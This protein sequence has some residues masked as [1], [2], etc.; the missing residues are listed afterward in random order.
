MSNIQVAAS[1]PANVTE[2]VFKYRFQKDD[3]G[4]QRP[5][6]EIKHQV[7]NLNGIKEILELPTSAPTGT[8][9]QNKE[10]QDAAEKIF[11]ANKAQQDLLLEAMDGIYRSVIKAWVVAD[12]NNTADKFDPAQF[13]WYAIATMEKEDRRSSAIPKEQWDSFGKDYAQIL[14]TVAGRTPEQIASAL[15]VFTKKFAPVKTN[16]PV[17]KFLQTQLALYIEHTKQGEQHSD[18]LDMLVK[19][20]DT[21]LQDKSA[22]SLVGN[23]GM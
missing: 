22:E 17:I 19:K 2:S 8:V 12:E 18:I 1:F 16:K 20:A 7:A 4:G 21:L 9:Y 5:A 23:L 14:S 10:E 15:Q 6:V 11:A 13:S 3:L